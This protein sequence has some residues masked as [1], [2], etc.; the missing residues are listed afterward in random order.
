MQCFKNAEKIYAVGIFDRA[1]QYGDG[2]F[3]TARLYQNHFELKARH[4]SRLKHAATHLFLDVDLELIEQSLL[5]LKNEYVELNGTL[6]I[7]I[8]RGEG[9]RGYSLPDHQ[10]DVYVYYYPSEVKCFE[11]Q[12]I[13]SGVLDSLMGLTMP[14]L[15]GIKSLN[16]IEQVILKKEADEK[17][18]IEALVCD[19]HG[20]VVEG[21]SSNCF[22]RINDQWITPEL[23]Y[24]GVHGVMRAEILQRMMQAGIDCQQRPIHQ[25][26]I[27]QFQ[28]IFFSNALS[29]MKVATHL[30]DT[31]L[32]TQICVELFQTLHLSQM[33]E[34]VKA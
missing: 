28:S 24:N 32:E 30:H 25:D 21:V 7:I 14:E 6:K 19:V 1:F 5:Q 34:Y 9:Q 31:I 8:S 2:C 18:W 20:Q 12:L 13:R 27:P 23:R 29:P 26:E 15:V 22:I 10:A 3:T 11:P 16:R 33:H 4:Y 17:G